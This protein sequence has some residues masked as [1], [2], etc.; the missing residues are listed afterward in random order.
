M[1]YI[2]EQIKDKLILDFGLDKTIIFCKMVSQMYKSLHDNL[3]K[4]KYTEME[5]TFYEYDYESIWWEDKYNEL[6]KRKDERTRPHG[7]VS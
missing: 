3:V 7:A 2:N 5:L 1:S 4:K 6:K